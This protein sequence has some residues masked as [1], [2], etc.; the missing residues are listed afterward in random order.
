MKFK[1]FTKKNIITNA[2]ISIFYLLWCHIIGGIRSEHYFL[3]V[4]WTAMFYISDKTRRIILG[5]SVFI[6]FW[7]IYDSMRII[8]NYEVSPVHIK[9]PYL[10]EKYLFGINYNNILLTPNEYFDIA[11]NKLLDF[12]SGFFY[13]NWMPVP[14]GF[15][16]YLY[17]KDKYLFIKFSL[18]FILVNLVGFI[19]Y[20]AYPAAPPW[21]VKLYGF[22]LH[23]GVPGNR[24]GLARFD[25][26]IGFPLFAN[27][28]NKNANV[29]AAMPSL[30]SAYPVV[31]LFYAVKK[32][33]GRVNIFFVI[34]MLGI[35]FSAVYSGHHYIIDII[36]GVSVALFVLIL[37]E[38][39]S[40]KPK[41][42]NL[43][44]NFMKKI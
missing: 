29:M 35:W 1:R 34:F 17:I 25:D 38:K 32:H 28:Y 14:I 27:I 10:S 3:V 33:L 5:F 20:Y 42:K 8:P 37:F 41:I 4:L 39:V 6:I 13:I 9:E 15:G 22:D 24:A 36:V 21:Y 43:L 30:H 16:I 44:R 26:L 11:H 7:I 2:L 12:I 31:V 18:A 23:L 19:I 40:Q